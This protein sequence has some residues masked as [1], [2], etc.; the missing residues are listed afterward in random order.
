MWEARLVRALRQSNADQDSEALA[1]AGRLVSL[2]DPAGV[3][4]GRY[5]VDARDAKGVQVGDRNVQVNRF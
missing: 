2:V 4:E 5:V 1:L 3:A